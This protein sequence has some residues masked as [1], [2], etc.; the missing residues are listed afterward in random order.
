MRNVPSLPGTYTQIRTVPYKKVEAPWMFFESTQKRNFTIPKKGRILSIS[1]L[2]HFFAGMRDSTFNYP[3][4]PWYVL[5]THT[6]ICTVP[7]RVL[8]MEFRISWQRIKILSSSEFWQFFVWICKFNFLVLLLAMWSAAIF[9]IQALCGSEC[10]VHP[11]KINLGNYL[12]WIPLS[13]F[14]LK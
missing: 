5:G 7:L 1:G 8:K 11:I 2:W 13:V 4:R 14:I 3:Y 9:L 10:E 6:Q 12:T